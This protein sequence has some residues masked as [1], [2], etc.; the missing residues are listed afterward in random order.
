LN[1]TNFVNKLTEDRGVIW[2]KCGKKEEDEE[3]ENKNESNY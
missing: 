1:I 2:I 3:G